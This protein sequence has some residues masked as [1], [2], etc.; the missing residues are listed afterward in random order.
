MVKKLG[1]FSTLFLISFLPVIVKAQVV[2][3]NDKVI[4]NRVHICSFYEKN[5]DYF[6]VNVAEFTNSYSEKFHHDNHCPIY[7]RVITYKDYYY[8]GVDND[9]KRYTTELI[10]SRVRESAIG[11]YLI[12]PDTCIKLEQV[13]KLLDIGFQNYYM[14]KECKSLRIEQ[15]KVNPQEYIDE[16]QCEL[17]DFL[18]K[19][20]LNC[21]LSKKKERFV[22]RF[23]SK[24]KVVC[25]SSS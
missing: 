4:D 18:I 22:K 7:I 9:G 23:K 13:A 19:S 17:S 11:I 25:Y 14:L 8:V 24:N 20:A 3:L 10:F 16:N 5:K 15:M 2:T 12:L 21:E 6:Y 1:I